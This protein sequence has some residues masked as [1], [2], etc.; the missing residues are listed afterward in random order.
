MLIIPVRA[1]EVVLAAA[2]Q[3]TVES[4]V[5]EVDVVIVSHEALL[6]SLH[7]KVVLFVVNENDPV[8]PAGFA[9]AVKR[10]SVSIPG[11]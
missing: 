8:S 3:F 7:C 4:P 6:A 5:P 2:A 10:A 1:L 11:A 9:I